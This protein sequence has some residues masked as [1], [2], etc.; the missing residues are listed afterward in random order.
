[1]KQKLK[2]FMAGFMAMLTLVGTLFTNGTT[3]FAAS[4][5][6]NIAFWNASV[7][8]SGE[9]SEL[10]PGY[11]HGKILY[12]I[13]DGN[14]A[15]CM[16]FG[17]R[18]DGGQLM[19]S[20]DDASTSMSAQQR[21]LLSYCLY[22]G[23]NSTQKAA[24]SNSQCDEYIAT[25]AMVWVIVADIFGTGSGDS[26]ARKLCNTAPSPDS[27]Y[28][29]YERLRDN[30]SSS[31]NATLPSFA[32]RRTS[33]APTYELK[34]NEGSQ[35][36]ETTLSDSNGVLSDFDFGISGYSVDKNGNSIT[37]PTIRKY[38]AERAELV[39]AVRLPNTAFKDNAG[40]EVT[41]DILFLQ[42][43]E[44]KIDIEPDWVHLGVTENGIAVNSYFAEHPEMMLGSM[45][46]DTR[47]YGQD[48]RY[49]VCV[50]NDENFNMYETLNKAI[51]NIKA[52]MTDFERVAD[53]AEQTEEVIPADPDVRN[54]TYTFFEGKLYYRENSEMVR[55]EVSKT[56][57]E[58]IR[59]LDE[60]RQITREL[61]DIQMDGCSEEELSD[62]Q[63]LLNVKYDA[64]VKQYGA[65][66]SKAN[67]IAFRDDS[68]YPLLC[69]LEEVNEDGEVK[70]AD[71]FYKQTIKA[72]TVIDRVETAV[73]AL[74]VSVNEF[75]YVNLAYMLSIY[76]P[77]ITNAKEE[78]A[79]ESGQTVDEI[80]LS[81]DALAELRRA[82]LVEE[83]DGLIFLNPDRYNENNPDIGWETAD[84]YLSGNVRDK[85][86]VAKAMAADT[87]NPQAERFAGNVAALEKVQP[88]WIEASDIDVKIGTTWIEPLDYEQFI[89]ELLNTPR[90]ARAV[91]SQFYN[92]GI[93]VH[94][95]KM[96]MEWFIENK[97]MDKHSV[98]A[99]KT[100]GTSRM[101]AYSIFEDTLNLKTVTVRDR[102][103]DGDGRY[104]Y[105][106]NKNETMLAREKQNMIKEKFKEWLFAEPERRQKYVEY[107]NETFNNIRLREYDG[108][109]LQFPG[110]NPAIE[111]KPHQKNAVARILLG[112]NTLLAHCVGAGKSF[113]MM[114]ACMEQKRL[115]LANKTK[116]IEQYQNDL[117]ASKAEYDK[118]FA[119]S[120]ELNEK[121]A[122][123]CELNAQLDL[124]NA[125]AVDA[126]LS[127]P[128][129]ERE[130]DERME[131]AAIV[132]ED[133]GAYPSDR[134]G[135]T[136]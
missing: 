97:S 117:E 57:E 103:D 89:Y 17:L 28:S 69:S 62:K 9:V 30:I 19:N 96:S 71:M 2:R 14:S 104:H 31:Y 33:E 134:E 12:S 46:Y 98:A 54:Y 84:E 36:F 131:S 121:L 3:A 72:K 114:A 24:P 102:I 56:A 68:D 53:E 39:G 127:G 41:A 74:N 65:I 75:G 136:R 6:A 55:K 58:R 116:K 29:Y 66:T 128:E 133:K 45:E 61:I 11:N 85:L 91:R 51:G 112:G 50:N 81:D 107:Y 93:Q 43:R 129:E 1:M 95:N 64:F 52:Q 13:L 135:R 15:Y 5:Q 63:R 108:S 47:I 113:E 38:L 118:P 60:I 94:L 101:D 22:Y 119:Y 26:A 110:M 73:E 32:S 99:T 23:F 77:D 90:R 132:A 88:E 59:S 109:H 37:N 42:K 83:L 20:Y 48:S 105:E 27:S 126:D 44:R 79:E 34:W 125:K 100:Y 92:T 115:G 111:L 123:Q 4:P 16:N 10:K 18:A 87:D 122:R 8:N 80:T 76:E 7:K 130:A 78:L 120:E 40:T 106:V 86:R 124:E 67:R 70:K 21:K 49:T 25:Q 82:V 35:R